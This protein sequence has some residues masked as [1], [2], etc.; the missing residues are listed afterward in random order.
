[1]PGLTKHFKDWQ[2][3]NKVKVEF[4][5]ARP[6]YYSTTSLRGHLGNQV[7]SLIRSC[8]ESPN[9][10][11]IIQ[12]SH[13]TS[14]IRSPRYSGLRS[15]F[16]CKKLNITSVLRSPRPLISIIAVISGCVKVWKHGRAI[17]L[18]P[19]FNVLLLRSNVPYPDRLLSYCDNRFD[20]EAR[21]WSL[22]SIML[23]IIL[24]FSLRQLHRIRVYIGH[25]VFVAP[26]AGRYLTKIP[27][28]W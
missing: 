5:E 23:V 1:M 3:Q 26:H 11:P 17:S 20:Y 19:I 28:I 9:E 8:W 18:K 27:V 24:Y 16:K 7:T 2:C 4:G 25:A 14:L 22:I 21:T 6:I 15:S 12:Y 10:K 13:R